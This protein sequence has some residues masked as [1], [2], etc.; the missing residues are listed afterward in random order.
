MLIL[1]ISLGISFIGLNVGIN[2]SFYGNGYSLNHGCFRALLAVIL[3]LGSIINIS[4]SRLK[5]YSL[6]TP[7]GN[8]S[9]NLLPKC[10]LN[11]KFLAYLISCHYGHDSSVG[12]PNYLNIKSNSSISFLP[13]NKAVF[14]TSSAKI[15]P[16]DQ[17]SIVA[18]Y[19]SQPS[20]T[21]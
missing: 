16:A 7:F 13:G 17:I 10:Y 9:S 1:L 19:L 14:A 8:L 2:Y 5:P 20:K 6:S 15:H 4:F 12:V 3:Q 11:L 21:F 18:E